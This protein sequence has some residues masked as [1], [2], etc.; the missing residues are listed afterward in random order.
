MNTKHLENISYNY[1]HTNKSLG[2]LPLCFG[3]QAN[4]PGNTTTS[5]QTIA[6]YA[7][8]R[9]KPFTNGKP[10]LHNLQKGATC[11]NWKCLVAPNRQELKKRKARRDHTAFARTEK[12]YWLNHTCVLTASFYS[13]VTMCKQYVYTPIW[14]KHKI[15]LYIKSGQKQYVFTCFL[16]CFVPWVRGLTRSP[17]P[18]P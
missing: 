16:W 5:T 17:R 1:H 14:V 15:S 13:I 10:N 8:I 6:C 3:S 2:I 9:F 18:T 7:S 12:P 4:L 11:F